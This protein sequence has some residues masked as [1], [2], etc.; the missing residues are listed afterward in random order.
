MKEMCTRALTWNIEYGYGI[1]IILIWKIEYNII[2]PFLLFSSSRFPSIISNYL[3]SCS[4]QSWETIGLS[5][6]SSSYIIFHSN[7]IQHYIFRRQ[8]WLNKCSRWLTNPETK[9]LK[10]TKWILI[11]PRLQFIKIFCHNFLRFCVNSTNHDNKSSYSGVF[12]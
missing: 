6:E 5:T 10:T 8:S 11:K 4:W 3:S 7:H 2:M 9:L 1:Y 12:C